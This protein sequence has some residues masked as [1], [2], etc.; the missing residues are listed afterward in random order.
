[1]SATWTWHALSSRHW[2]GLLSV[3]LQ[4]A[5]V[6]LDGEQWLT[7]CMLAVDA[8]VLV[9][10]GNQRMSILYLQSAAR[11]S[12]GECNACAAVVLPATVRELED[13]TAHDGRV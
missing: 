12:A 9:A 10:M 8:V 3:C 1:M 4:L 11:Q 6:W 5:C 2:R 13:S 7:A